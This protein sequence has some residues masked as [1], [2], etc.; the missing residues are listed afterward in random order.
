MREVFRG[1]NDMILRNLCVVFFASVAFLS[2]AVLPVQAAIVASWDFE[3]GS[4]N[5]VHDGV[6]GLNGTQTGGAWVASGDYNGALGTSLQLVR[7]EAD[8]VLIP[9]A[10]QLS[11]LTSATFE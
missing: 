2:I 9:Y 5:N 3:E 8:K 6:G 4:G 1:E 10:S 7:S 11:G